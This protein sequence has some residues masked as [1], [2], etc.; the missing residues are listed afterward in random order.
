MVVLVKGHD[1]VLYHVPPY[2]VVFFFLGHLSKEG[3]NL[4]R[5]LGRVA[6]PPTRWP[7]LGCRILLTFVNLATFRYY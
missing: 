7:E 1:S 2:L 3:C 4:C 6:L 5:M